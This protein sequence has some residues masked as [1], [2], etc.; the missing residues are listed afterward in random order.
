MG[1]LYEKLSRV[2]CYLCPLQRLNELKVIYKEYP[3]LWEKMKKLDDATI[4]KHGRQ[5]RN[6]YSIRELERKFKIEITLKENQL[7][8]F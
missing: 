7:K 8:M 3:D 4:K 1:G 2:S 5:F 6:D